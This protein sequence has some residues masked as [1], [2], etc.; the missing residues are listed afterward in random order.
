MT[1]PPDDERTVGAV[2]VGWEAVGV[3]ELV[4][5]L[6]EVVVLSAAVVA[7]PDVSVVD[8]TAVVAPPDVPR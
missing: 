1:W 7:A 4:D 5:E 6:V 3:G 8:T 2:D